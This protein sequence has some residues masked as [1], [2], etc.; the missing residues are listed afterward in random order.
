M[1]DPRLLTKLRLGNIRISVLIAGGLLALELLDH[2]DA[3]AERIAA[4]EEAL[5]VKAAHKRK[6]PRQRN[7]EHTSLFLFPSTMRTRDL[8]FAFSGAEGGGTQ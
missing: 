8:S 4:P 6:K 7:H 2:I 1:S 3:Q 5:A